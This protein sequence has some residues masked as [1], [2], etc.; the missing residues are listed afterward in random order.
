MYCAICVVHANM[1]W[2]TF[3][4]VD[5][6]SNARDSSCTLTPSHLSGPDYAHGTAENGGPS[7]LNDHDDIFPNH[8]SVSVTLEALRFNGCGAQ[9]YLYS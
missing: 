2:L 8:K 9:A 6:M 5:E 7:L 4:V 1:H 3:F